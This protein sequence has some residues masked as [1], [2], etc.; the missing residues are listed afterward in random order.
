MPN[1]IDPDIPHAAVIE[2]PEANPY[3]AA[4]GELEAQLR[5]LAAAFSQLDALKVEAAEITSECNEVIAEEKAIL[6]NPNGSEK[7]A[8]DKLLRIRATRDIRQAKL[9]NVQKRIAQHIDLLVND[10]GNQLRCDMSTLA[11][12]LLNVRTQRIEATFLSLIGQ[13]YDHGLPINAVDL[14]RVSK[15]VVAAQQLAN[16]IHREPRPTTE[17]ELAEL[18]SETPA[19]WLSEL[20]TIV[21][22]EAR[23]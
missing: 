2:S 22:A 12:A 13:V 6:E 20:R 4:L 5:G 17:E 19:R 11:Y 9:S 3:Q 8:V 15:P 14:T 16:W 21:E 18:R 10:L 1:T 23:H 7:A